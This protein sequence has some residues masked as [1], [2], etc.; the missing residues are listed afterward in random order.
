MGERQSEQHEGQSA[1]G[2][3]MKIGF[4]ASCYPRAVDTAVR[5]EV[6]GLRELGHRVDTFSVRRAEVSQ[7]T[8]ELHRQEHATTTYIV[9]D[10]LYETPLSALKLFARSPLRFMRALALARRTRPEGLRGL[11]LQTAYFLE[12]AYLADQLLKRG[13]E[14][15]HNHI[16]ENSASVAMLASALSGVPYSLTIHGPYI[17]R[18]P[19]R[20]AL[21]E[22]IVRSVFTVAITSFTRSQCMM[23]VPV[24]AWSR[25]HIV[26]CGPEAEL[27]KSEPPPLPAKGAGP[28]R[29]RRLV[30]VGR[31]CEEKGVPVLLEASER[32]VR[33][34][35]AFELVMVGE[36]PLRGAAEAV[37]RERGLGEQI[38]ITGWMNGEEVREQIARSHA[39]VLPS[40]AE[41]LPAV[42]MEAMALRR[43]A[44]STYIAGI[45][46][47]IEPGQNGW[48]VPAGSVDALVDAMREV[49]Q[50]PVSE[51]ERLGRASRDAVLRLHNTPVE[52]RKLE[53]L[54]R[55]SIEARSD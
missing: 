44:I 22:K 53:G 32:L 51:L 33:E 2:A 21:G 23:F 11:A 34:G 27:L 6:I 31:I 8:S 24:E 14:H 10:H 16:G 25:L 15:F 47:L 40:F 39:M 54:I 20:W 19:E 7:L 52:V 55:E 38:I 43:P 35:L 9:S 13:I 50:A 1:R 49:I 28:G 41:G 42:I 17:F 36:G 4:L 18:A 5:N 29:G 30:W 46:E 3:S 12:A 48:L 37:I 45:P 26:R